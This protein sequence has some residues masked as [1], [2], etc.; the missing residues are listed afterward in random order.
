[1]ENKN[2]YV[3]L[4]SHAI[5]LDHK[6]PYTRNGKRFYRPYRNYYDA[7]PK[8]CDHWETMC[9]AGF[10]KRGHED[11]Y[12]GRMYRL[13]RDGLDWLGKE[14]NIKIYDEDD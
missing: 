13:S 3:A 1:M 10:A 11:R 4:A 8:D 2:H 7:S 12:G 5:G 9:G 14:L 6:N